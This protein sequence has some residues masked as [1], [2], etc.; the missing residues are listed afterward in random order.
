MFTHQIDDNTQTSIRI[1]GIARPIAWTPLTKDDL[2]FKTGALHQHLQS[3]HLEPSEQ[4]HLVDV[5]AGKQPFASIGM[6]DDSWTF[7]RFDQ[8]HKL[9]PAPPSWAIWAQHQITADSI[10]KKLDQHGSGVIWGAVYGGMCVLISLTVFDWNKYAQ[11][12]QSFA[13]LLLAITLWSALP[14]TTLKVVAFVF[15][16]RANFAKP[17]TE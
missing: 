5:L 15:E 8:D 11:S 16:F 4:S 14:L 13:M 2:E 1:P 17:N 6:D 7:W 12:Y 3:I 9:E 10:R